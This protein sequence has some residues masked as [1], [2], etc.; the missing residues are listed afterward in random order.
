MH[1]PTGGSDNGASGDLVK[2][3]LPSD[4][5]TATVVDWMGNTTEGEG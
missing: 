5:Q 3:S 4:L 2:D 1:P